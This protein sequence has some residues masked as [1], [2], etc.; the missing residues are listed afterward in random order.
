MFTPRGY[1]PKIISDEDA[2]AFF[3]GTQTKDKRKGFGVAP[4][5]IIVDMTRAF[6]EDRF[7]TGYERTGRPATQANA[8]L[9]TGA[10]AAQIPIFF[11]LGAGGA[12]PAERGLWGGRSEWKPADRKGETGNEI[13]PEIAPIEGE[14]LVPKGKPSGFFGTQLASHLNYYKVDT[15][16]ITG[17]TTSGCVRATVVDAFSYNYL[18]TVPVECVADRS[19]V[20]HEV[21]LF[22][23]DMKYADVLPLDEVLRYLRGFESNRKAV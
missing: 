5:V 12:T 18:V 11:T 17:M 10:R 22:D 1:I 15:L 14:T 16:I 7:P 9:L 21:S 8:R 3:K 13:M 23:M 6:V 20:S 4:A 19:Q 2:G